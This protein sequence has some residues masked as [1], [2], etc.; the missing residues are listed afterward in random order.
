MFASVPTG[1]AMAI[2]HHP[3]GTF[4]VD[5]QRSCPPKCSARMSLSIPRWNQMAAFPELPGTA[6]AAGFQ[7][8]CVSSRCLCG[9]PTP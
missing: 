2:K 8:R 1:Q 9:C 4:C 6:A 7:D 5:V 3:S